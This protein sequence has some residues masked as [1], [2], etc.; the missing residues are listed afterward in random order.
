[1]KNPKGWKHVTKL[2]HGRKP[3]VGSGQGPLPD[4]HTWAEKPVTTKSKP[5]RKQ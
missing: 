4:V 2:K 3:P 1:M 5:K